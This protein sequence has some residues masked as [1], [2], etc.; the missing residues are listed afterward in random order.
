MSRVTSRTVEAPTAPAPA[1]PAAVWTSL[2]LVY[3]IWGSTYLAI[4]ITVESAPPMMSMGLRFVTAALLLG[5]FLVVRRG[6]AVLRVTRR[7]VA[8]SAIVGFLLLFCGMGGLSYAERH[9][10]TGIAALIVAVVPLWVVL[11]RLT[12]GDHPRPLTWIGIGI[13]L[14]GLAVLLHPGGSG[15]SPLGWSLLIM[16]GSACWALGSFLQPKLDTPRNPLVLSFYEM[17]TGGAVLLLVGSG[18]GERVSPSTLTASSIWAWVYLVAIGS[19]VGYVAYVWLLDNAPLSLVS[20]YAYVNPVVAVGL[21]V[22]LHGEKVTGGLLLGG[23][24]VVAGVVLVVT[25]ERQSKLAAT[26]VPECVT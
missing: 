3:V 26:A 6:P 23:A 22:L 18:I 8:S 19:L 21:G 16:G 24:I 1:S 15:G 7:Q 14:V 17:L 20:T 10:D 9:V 5:G 12:A 25:G 4:A 11:L 13:G 2:S